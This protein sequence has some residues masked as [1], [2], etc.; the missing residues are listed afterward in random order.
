MAKR[1]KPHW[2]GWFYGPDGAAAIFRSKDEVPKGWEDHPSK[3]KAGKKEEPPEPVPAKK[4][5]PVSKAPVKH[6]L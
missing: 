6:D 3:V 2:P 1:D 5:E 4:P